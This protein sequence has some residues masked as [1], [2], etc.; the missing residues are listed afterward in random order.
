MVPPASN[1]ISRVSLY[2]GA[3]QLLSA[4]HT[5]LLRS[6]DPAFQPFI[7]LASNIAFLQSTTPLNLSLTVWPLPLSLATTYGISVDFSSWS[8]LDVSVHSVFLL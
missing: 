2:S 1:E 8:Y 4:S 5:R 7:L 3:V 6:L